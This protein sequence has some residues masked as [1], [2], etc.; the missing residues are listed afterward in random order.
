MSRR[1]FPAVYADEDGE[2]GLT[3]TVKAEPNQ[4]EPFKL[5]EVKAKKAERNRD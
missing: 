3:A 4:L 5:V 2:T 1:P